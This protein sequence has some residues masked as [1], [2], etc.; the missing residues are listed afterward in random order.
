[1]TG[2][3]LDPL[4]LLLYAIPNFAFWL[5]AFFIGR[6]IRRSNPA[7]LPLG[8]I[9]LYVCVW[10]DA[11]LCILAIAAGQ[12]LQAVFRVGALCVT[13]Y[14]LLHLHF[15]HVQYVKL[16]MAEFAWAARLDKQ[17][18]AFYLVVLMSGAF[19][20]VTQAAMMF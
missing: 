2:A 13:A 3:M 4:S 10:I 15:L 1:M 20:G 8:K 9:V 18:P 7:Y 14:A 12:P 16:V 19:C 11:T 6:H 17:Y 5:F